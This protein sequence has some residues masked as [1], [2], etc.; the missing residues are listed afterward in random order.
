MW[1]QTWRPLTRLFYHFFCTLSSLKKTCWATFLASFG[2]LKKI[3]YHFFCHFQLF[4]AIWR[5]FKQFKAI[6]LEPFG[7]IWSHTG[8]PFLCFF[9][10]FFFAFLG[11]FSSFLGNF[12]LP[13]WHRVGIFFLRFNIFGCIWSHFEPFGGFS[14]HLEPFG[15][16]LGNLNL[17]FFGEGGIF[18]TFSSL[19]FFFLALFWPFFG[20]FV[21]MV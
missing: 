5:Y 1:S 20:F 2:I 7:A 4:Q 6:H 19:N 21:W 13:F 9:F 11:L 16:R 14:S 18:C 10:L 15:A 12:L 8:K 17:I 3:V